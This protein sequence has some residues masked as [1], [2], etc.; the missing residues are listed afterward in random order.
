MF[1]ALEGVILT[2]LE[3]TRLL[4]PEP[5]V[6]AITEGTAVASEGKDCR[7]STSPEGQRVAQINMFVQ[8]KYAIVPT[9]I[10]IP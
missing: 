8:A 1:R 3:T 9:A 5:A 4:V 10:G 6:C 2:V 7:I